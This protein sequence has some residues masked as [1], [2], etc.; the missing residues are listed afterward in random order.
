MKK[1]MII[2]GVP[3]AGKSTISQRIAKQWGYQHISM[4]SILAG[5]EKT[6]PETGIDTN[7]NMEETEKLAF[8]SSKISVFIRNMI[9]SGEYDECDY[10]M[11]IDIYQLLPQDF[12]QNLDPAVCDIFYFITSNVTG[13]ERF[14]ILKKYDTPN[15]YT[16][17]HSDAQNRDDCFDIVKI[18][19]LIKEQCEQYNLPCYE[20]AFNREAVFED[21]LSKLKV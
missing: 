2:A 16:Y 7:Q 13:E 14:E 15:D 10:G 4:D 20:T 8:I 1:H 11:V 5:I 21:F 17:Y 9:D 6:F 12:I 18:S 19:R 3:R